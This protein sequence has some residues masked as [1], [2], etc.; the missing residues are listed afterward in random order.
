MILSPPQG[1]A[2]QR[3]YVRLVTK[4]DRYPA[5]EIPVS[6]LVMQGIKWC[7]GRKKIALNPRLLY[8]IFNDEAASGARL[9]YLCV[10]FIIGGVIIGLPLMHC[11]SRWCTWNELV[12]AHTSLIII[13]IQQNDVTEGH[14]IP[15]ASEC[16]PLLLA[17]NHYSFPLLFSGWRR[18]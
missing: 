10:E 8:P 11:K 5:L 18:V 13:C 17:R 15:P 7:L 12:H 3:P 6:G 9:K 4:Q 16:L 1:F 14:N 2:D